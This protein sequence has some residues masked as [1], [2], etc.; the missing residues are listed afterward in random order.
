MSA[1]SFSSSS[2]L[3]VGGRAIRLACPNSNLFRAARARTASPGEVDV[4]KET[5]TYFAG[6][7]RRARAV[8][9]LALGIGTGLLGSGAQSDER[10]R[11]NAATDHQPEYQ[12]HT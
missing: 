9:G 12:P 6:N 8:S 4:L 10:A 3:I 7:C 11:K 5:E 2:A 1:A